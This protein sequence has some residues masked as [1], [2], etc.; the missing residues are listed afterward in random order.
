[1]DTADIAVTVADEW[2]GRGVGSTL[3]REL[4]LRRPAGVTRLVTIISAQNA[5]ALALLTRLGEATW[6]P[7]GHGTYL[8]IVDLPD[9]PSRIGDLP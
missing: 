8:V 6:I 3:A 5:A 9:N 1:V 7:S 2:Q 4:V